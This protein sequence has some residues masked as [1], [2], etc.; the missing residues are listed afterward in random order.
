MSRFTEIGFQG[1]DAG[2]SVC[3]VEMCEGEV[4]RVGKV[5]GMRVEER[6]VFFDC[7][8]EISLSQ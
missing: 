3:H 7:G 6:G 1:C 2:L 4:V 8:G 5:M